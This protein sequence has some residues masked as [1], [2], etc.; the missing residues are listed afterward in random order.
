MLKRF[1]P[2]DDNFFKL[3]REAINQLV[4]ITIKHQALVNNLSQ[5]S[6]Y[7]QEMQLIEQAGDKT[8]SATF[9][10]LHKTFITPFDRYDIHRLVSRLES[11]VDDILRSAQTIQVYELSSLPQEVVTIVDSSVQCASMMKTAI[12]QLKS[13]KNTADILKC[14]ETV[15]DAED[16]AQEL[17]LTAIGRLFKDENDIKQLLKMRELLEGLKDIMEGFQ[18]LANVIRTIVLEYA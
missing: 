5:T 4:Q 12:E 8:I 15:S 16:M 11:L 9:N 1:L 17:I 2:Q 18:E 10:L 14:C 7:L 6:T 13:L 3:F